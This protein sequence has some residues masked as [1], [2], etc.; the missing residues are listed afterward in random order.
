MG[1]SDTG[2]VL[3]DI[4]NPAS[5]SQVSVA[6][7]PAS[8]DGEVNSSSVRPSESGAIVIEGEEDGTL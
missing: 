2:L 1:V 4:S 5:P 8:E 6:I 7:A 3:L